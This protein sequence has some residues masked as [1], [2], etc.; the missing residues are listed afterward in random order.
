MF[1][2]LPQSHDNVLGVKAIGKITAK[3]YEDILIPR[4]DDL[5]K[6][7]ENGR[8]LYYL[9]ND[10]EGFEAGA[11]WD[12]MK[13]GKAHMDKFERIAVVTDSKWMEWSSDF[14]SKFIPGEMKAF[15]TDQLDEAWKWLE[16]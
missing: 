4:L 6:N 12:D 11:M 5:L 2:I 7:S 13:Y 8:F 1:E 3:D 9:G 14:F 16:S 15:H 10:F